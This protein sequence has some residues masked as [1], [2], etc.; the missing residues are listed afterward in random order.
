MFLITF[1]EGNGRAEIEKN[2]FNDTFVCDNDAH[3]IVLCTCSPFFCTRWVLL[4]NQFKDAAHDKNLKFKNLLS[5]KWEKTQGKLT[6]FSKNCKNHILGQNS[7]FR[8]KSRVFEL[9]K[10]IP[11]HVFLSISKS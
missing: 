11:V 10:C 2:N 5:K 3:K 4:R 9:K 1:S 6:G 8:K 7:G